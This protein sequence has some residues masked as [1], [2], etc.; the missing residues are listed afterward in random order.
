MLHHFHEGFSEVHPAGNDL[1]P[2]IVGIEKPFLVGVTAPWLTV[3]VMMP[4]WIIL[5]FVRQA[6]E[7]E[8]TRFVVADEIFICVQDEASQGMTN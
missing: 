1:E 5:R 2:F 8:P 3:H 6:P 7:R 4:E